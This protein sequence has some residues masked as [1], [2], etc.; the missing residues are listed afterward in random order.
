[1]AADG[2]LVVGFDREVAVLRWWSV[3]E[4]PA[5]SNKGY[6]GIDVDRELQ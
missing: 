4:Q 3:S 5:L 6:E 1:M 2:R